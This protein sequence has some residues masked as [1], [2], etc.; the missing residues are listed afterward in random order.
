MEQEESLAIRRRSVTS[1]QARNCLDGCTE[2][3][4]VTLRTL[5][6]G[7]R[8]DRDIHAQRI[9][10][11]DCSGEVDSVLGTSRSGYWAGCPIFSNVAKPGLCRADDCAAGQESAGRD[12]A[13]TKE[14]AEGRGEAR[15]QA[16]GRT[17]VRA[18]G[19]GAVIA[20]AGSN[21]DALIPEQRSTPKRITNKSR[22]RQ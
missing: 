21:S 6:G 1:I 14:K 3:F 5:R 17:H 2:K 19:I 22:P 15:A 7:Q 8:I 13:G 20:L 18:A 4:V 12:Q 10:A 16:A 11:G 9:S